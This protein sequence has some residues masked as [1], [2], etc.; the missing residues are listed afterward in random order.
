MDF[1][2]VFG[3]DMLCMIPIKNVAVNTP[4]T[5][6]EAIDELEGKVEDD[7]LERLRGYTSSNYLTPNAAW[8]VT[9]GQAKSQYNYLSVEEGMESRFHDNRYIGQS[10]GTSGDRRYRANQLIWKTY[11]EFKAYREVIFLTMFNEYNEVVTEV[12]VAEAAAE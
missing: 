6:T 10:T 2:F 3:S 4:I 1:V 5:V 8:D 11:L 9:S 12:V 7:V